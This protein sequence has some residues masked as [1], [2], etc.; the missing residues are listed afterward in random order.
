[1]ALSTKQRRS[2]FRNSAK[3]I[4]LCSEI[5]Q[6]RKENFFDDHYLVWCWSCVRR[7]VADQR[8]LSIPLLLKS[9]SPRM[10]ARNS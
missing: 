1:M 5:R 9:P 3:G 10:E 2:R 7:W 4:A 6:A 8:D